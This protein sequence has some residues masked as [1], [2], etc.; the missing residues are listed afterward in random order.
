MSEPFNWK[1]AWFSAVLSTAILTLMWVKMVGK[2][3]TEHELQ[4]FG[5]LL[6]TF[7]W[8]IAWRLFYALFELQPNEKL[9]RDKP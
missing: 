7:V 4:I 8:L 3:P 2:E 6:G 1:S 5:V 9:E